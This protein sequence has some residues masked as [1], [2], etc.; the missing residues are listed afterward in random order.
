MKINPQLEFCNS[1]FSAQENKQQ[2]LLFDDN[3]KF[4]TY[5]DDLIK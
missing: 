1:E 4:F 2:K 3:W 5:F